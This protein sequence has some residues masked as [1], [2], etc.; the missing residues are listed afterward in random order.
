MPNPF[1]KLKD[2]LK[3][4]K[5]VGTSVE[6]Q[7]ENVAPVAAAAA[8]ANSNGEASNNEALPTY[9]L[10]DPLPAQPIDGPTAEALSAAFSSL[11]LSDT[12]LALPDTDT[13]LAHLKLLSTFHAL[14]EDVGYT[15]GLF[16]L[17]DAKCEL[18]DNREES[19]AK[20]REKRWVL[21]IARA[22]ERFED[23]WLQVLCN[24]EDAKRLEGKEMR[25]NVLKFMEFTKR[26]RVQKWTTSML[27]PIGMK[28]LCSLAIG[29]TDT[30]RCSYGMA[31]LYAES[32]KLLGRL[33]Q[34]W[35][36]RSMGDWYAMACSQCCHR[37]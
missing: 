35:T 30:H 15:D 22:V 34:V 28:P 12:P 37:Y 21:F 29:F 9:A 23:W 26:G 6:K 16:N 24:A 1:G 2:S 14:K 32:S 36:E 20:M 5:S 33:H 8:T 27:P 13:C 3:G 19:L 17:W 4:D 18:L 10:T 31:R 11:R 25:A 7:Q